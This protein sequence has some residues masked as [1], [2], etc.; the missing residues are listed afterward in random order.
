MN[1]KGVILIVED[2]PNIT[3]VLEEI[4]SYDY[5]VITSVNGEDALALLEIKQPDMIIADISMP[6]M[7]GFELLLNLKRIGLAIKIPLLY[8]TARGQMSEVEK[9][10]KL[11]AYG[12]MVKPFL[13]SRLI[14][15]VEEIFDKLER[16]KNIFSA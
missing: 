4:L 7:D 3:G 6:V 9:G 16:R 1:T 12:Y 2:E 14:A 13:P 15:K 10:L 8:L 5:T 11:G